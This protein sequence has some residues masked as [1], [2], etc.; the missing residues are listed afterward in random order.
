MTYPSASFDWNQ[1]RAFLATA[2][3]GSLSAAAR[4]LGQ[5][6]PTLGRQIAALEERLGV[7]LFDRVGRTLVLTP[8]GQELLPH[9]RAMEE[10]ASR[11]AL[12]ATGQAQSVR[13]HVSISA[14]DVLTVHVLPPIIARLSRLAPE[15]E[16]TLLA[17]N[18]LADIPRREADIAVRHVRPTQPDLTARLVGEGQGR[19]YAA[20][21]YLDR[22]GRPKDPAEMATHT[23]IGF[24]D[25][26]TTLA[27][28]A[29]RGIPLRREAI[30]HT[31][32][33]AL[34]LWE[35]VKQGLGVTIM[36]E[37]LGNTTPGVEAILPEITF[38]YPF[39]LVTHRELHT[40]KRI[41]IVYDHLAD[42][43]AAHISR[44]A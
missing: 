13:G 20:T 26:E 16:V 1:A 7:T 41:R 31:T 29:Q 43:L 14:S 39:W 6:Q 5:T 11:M 22:V 3:E 17:Q 8:S 9:I 37:T 30:R 15:I 35:L 34:A 36:T 32:D 27:Y 28:M 42:S 40:S 38:P 33:S 23:Y 24:T 10:A 4:A 44:R 2:E 25:N 19:F 18:N 21:S 12:T